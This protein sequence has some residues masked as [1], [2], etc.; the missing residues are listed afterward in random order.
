MGKVGSIF[1]DARL[2]KGLT[3]EQVSDETNISRRFLQGIETDNFEGFPGEVY[4]LGF[5][6]N[7]AEFLGLDAARIVELYRKSDGE[8]EQASGKPLSVGAG[9]SD[10]GE[11]DEKAPAPEPLPSPALETTEKS[12]NDEAPAQ[13]Q[14]QEPSL[15]SETEGQE[16]PLS[17][18]AAPSDSSKKR[19]TSANRKPRVKAAPQE[20]KTKDQGEPQ[21][22]TIREPSPPPQTQQT[23]EPSPPPPHRIAFVQTGR[24]LLFILLG[25]VLLIAAI[26]IIPTLKLPSGTSRAPSEYRAEGLPFE[27]RL[28]PQDKVYLPLGDD[29]ISITLK[30]IKD[31]VTF[32]TP[33][34]ALT[35]GLNEEAVITPSADQERLV[36]TV[37]DYSPNEPKNGALVHFDVKEA[38]S[39]AESSG[40]I[41]VPGGTNQ[42]AAP[43]TAQGQQAP[44]V[45]LFR[46]PGGPHPF[47]VN[48]SFMSPV[49][50]RYEADRKEWVEKYYR[51]GE[52]IT[53]NASNSIT[54]WT[55]NAQAV[56]VN[57]F[58][59]AGKSTELVMGGPGEI[60][61]QRL[62]WSNAQGG[63]A[64]VAAP[65]D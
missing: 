18:Y 28:Y 42:A 58:Q 13:P 40:D 27:Q 32:D 47:Y 43:Q 8:A 61:V 59:S 31:K 7:Y 1:R 4:I 41:T 24:L 6:R 10:I 51:K 12:R 53:I 14:A 3:L 48:V 21:E 16:S 55:A 50:F 46:S 64:M 49:L 26:S 17:P 45:V 19:K 60:A 23:S 11:K 36:A 57:V 9:R 65:L 63:W 29:F 62:S 5:L 22:S 2:E 30:A 38:L 15:F 56:K 37:T 44:P 20:D 25:L 34:G 35:T 39:Q 54:F 52:S 33:Y